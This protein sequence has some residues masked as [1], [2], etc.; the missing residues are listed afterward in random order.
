MSAANDDTIAY[1]RD[2]IAAMQRRNDHLEAILERRWQ[3]A[4]QRDIADA[5]REEIG[6]VGSLSRKLSISDLETLGRILAELDLGAIQS[7]IAAAIEFRTAEQA[8]I[9]RR[10]AARLANPA[11]QQRFATVEDARRA[12][13]ER[14]QVDAEA[15]DAAWD[16][17]TASIGEAVSRTADPANAATGQI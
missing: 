10:Q 9:E 11:W 15:R 6:A 13:R 4:K 3:E 5:Q 12:V 2:T 7:G 14:R 16:R 1:L 17:L 8:N